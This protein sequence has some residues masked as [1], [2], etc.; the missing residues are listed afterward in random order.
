MSNKIK[1]LQRV[2][3]LAIFVG[4]LPFVINA[5]ARESRWMD[6]PH[7]KVGLTYGVSQ[8][9]QTAYIWRGLYVG[10]WNT[11]IDANVGYGGLYIDMWWNIGSVDWKFSAFQPEVDFT[12]GFN[13]WC[14][15]PYVAFIHNFNCPF[16]DFSN[17][18][19]GGNSLELG[20]KYTVSS[21][22]PL[23]VKWTTRVAASDGY[24]RETVTDDGTVVTDTLRAYSS[25][26]EVSY[27]HPFRDGYFITGAVGFTPWRSLYTGYQD[28]AALTNIDLQV[29]KH[30]TVH[31]RLGL[32]LMGE[33]C[34]NPS[35]P[36]HV[37]N[38]NIGLGIYLK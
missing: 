31:P 5:G 33:I 9:V 30:W 18:P 12:I 32:K 11:Q 22:I 19:N 3:A 14:V 16:F 13:R 7:E 35:A 23:T 17:H 29:G 20:L 24:L 8:T 15:H 34:V 2:V 36:I 37:I 27:T 38:T 21:K 10:G 6:D 4:A 1:Q 25:Y 26:A 28:R